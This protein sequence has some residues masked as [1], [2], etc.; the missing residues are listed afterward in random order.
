MQERVYTEGRLS[1]TV[2][3]PRGTADY[4]DGRLKPWAEFLAAG[5]A[6]ISSEPAGRLLGWRA[7]ARSGRAPAHTS[8]VNL[9]AT[10]SAQ[11][12]AEQ[13]ESS[14]S[15]GRELGRAE[16]LKAS[17]RVTPS[18]SAAERPPDSTPQRTC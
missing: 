8:R 16:A 18:T 2:L 15:T 6:G 4:S 10:A 12:A 14:D 3:D 13:P 17:T 5:E 1:V 11:R 7:D 9:R